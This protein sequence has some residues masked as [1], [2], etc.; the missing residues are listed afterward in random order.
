M[1]NMSTLAYHESMADRLQFDTK[2]S[3]EGRIVLPASARA[4]LGI[5]P[6]DRVHVTVHGGEARLVT[7]QSLLHGV[8]AKNHGGDARDS[9]TDVRR[10]R[11]DDQSR[12]AAKWERVNKSLAEDTRSEEQIEVDLLAALGIPQ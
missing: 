3:P 2:V 11:R 10:S 4:A 9:V 1:T 12:A 5:K 8:W 6:G 7:A